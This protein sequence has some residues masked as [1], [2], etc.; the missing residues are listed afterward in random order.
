[1]VNLQIFFLYSTGEY[2]QRADP[3]KGKH[4]I[5]KKQAKNHEYLIFSIKFPKN[6]HY[7]LQLESLE[8]NLPNSNF[9]KF[10]E[11]ENMYHKKYQRGWVEI[12][13]KF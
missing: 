11:N 13:M 2:F 4:L 6:I 1:M 9:S 7:I 3:L 8:Q 12:N 10:V 5:H